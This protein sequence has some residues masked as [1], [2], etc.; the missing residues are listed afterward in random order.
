ME[1]G[2]LDLAM[3][4]HASGPS[5]EALAVALEGTHRVH[6]RRKSPRRKEGRKS[7][8]EGRAKKST[9]EPSKRTLRPPYV[10]NQF[11][12]TCLEPTN[13]DI[14]ISFK[15]IYKKK[16]KGELSSTKKYKHVYN[17]NNNQI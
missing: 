2:M 17:Q 4:L 12:R 16:Y 13:K 6:P 11:M 7:R 14:C 1:E 10:Y 15:T 5:V 9:D 3:P 8:Q